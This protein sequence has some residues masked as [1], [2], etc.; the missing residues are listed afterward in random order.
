MAT[1]VKEG[2]EPATAKPS[3]ESGAGAKQQQQ[4]GE[5]K[6]IERRREGGL[7]LRRSLLGF[8]DLG[9]MLSSPFDIM[10]RMLEDFGSF[11]GIAAWTPSVDVFERG[12]QLVVRADLP[13]MT[14]DD[15][16]VEILD[17]G[18]LLEG[19]RRE[20]RESEEGGVWRSERR[21]GS[22]RRL[23]PLPEDIINPEQVTASFKDGV[24]E[25]TVGLPEREKAK[26][27]R[28][29]ITEGEVPQTGKVKH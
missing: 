19:E 9:F 29:E 2:K 24:L 5:Q 13:G 16:R 7:G 12:G 26:G 6:Q 4:E 15:V 25:V 8:P 17:D 22:F 10:R 11:G 3:V 20:E 28:V 27:R 21:S 18:L 1:Q 14:K 23:I